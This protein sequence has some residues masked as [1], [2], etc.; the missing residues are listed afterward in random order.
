VTPHDAQQASPTEATLVISVD[1]GPM[2]KV[3]ADAML[4]ELRTPA[5]TSPWLDIEKASAYLTCSPERVRKL[6][7]HRDI[8]FHQDRPGGRIFFNRHELDAW[9]LQ[10]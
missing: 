5:S 10:K 4:E 2:A 3:L 8:P 6:V 9:L 1:L 7:G